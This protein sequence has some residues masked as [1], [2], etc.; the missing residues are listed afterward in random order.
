[1][2]SQRKQIKSLEEELAANQKLLER[3]LIARPV[4]LELDRLKSE[5]EGE[6]AESMANMARARQNIGETELQILNE[7][8]RR[9]DEITSDLADTRSELAAVNERLNAQADILKR[10]VIKAP[11]AGAVHNKRFFTTGGVIQPGEAILD[12][13]PNEAELLID[14]RVSPVDIDVVAAGQEAR[15]NFLSF[16]ARNLPQINGFVRSVSADSLLDEVTGE[17]YY[18]AFVKVP[19]DEME[20]LGEQLSINAGMPAEVLIMTGER[21]MLQYL[22]DP[23]VESLRRSFR[24]S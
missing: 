13:V 7:D 20:K 5:I 10:T 15:V 22:L 8:A 4:F 21:T 3:D 12:I 23:L 17:S 2:K 19:Q 1:M 9:L 18:R 6:L 14:A 11:V 24:E 16:T